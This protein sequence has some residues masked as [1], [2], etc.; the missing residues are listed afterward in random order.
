MDALPP[1]NRRKREVC[2]LACLED[3]PPDDDAWPFTLG[4]RSIKRIS[5]ARLEILFSKLD[6]ANSRHSFT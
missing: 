2:L 1:L 5:Q 6:M 3:S 4:A